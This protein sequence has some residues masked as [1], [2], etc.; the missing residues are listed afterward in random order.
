MPREL[1][2]LRA[3]ASSRL[4]RVASPAHTTHRVCASLPRHLIIQSDSVSTVTSLRILLLIQPSDIE[5]FV[6]PPDHPKRLGLNR[7]FAS[8]PSPHPAFRHRNFCPAQRLV[9]H[10][11]PLQGHDRN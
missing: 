5:T 2:R 3:T 4:I 9:L 10:C 8:Y 6:P 7:H 11:M 1:M